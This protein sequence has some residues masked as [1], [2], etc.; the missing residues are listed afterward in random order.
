MSSDATME[1]DKDLQLLDEIKDYEVLFKSSSFLDLFII[2]T[3][4]FLFLVAKI[5]FAIYFC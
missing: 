5:I 2:R 4:I 3:K 1:I